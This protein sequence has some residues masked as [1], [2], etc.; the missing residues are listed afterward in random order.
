MILSVGMY[1]TTSAIANIGYNYGKEKGI[2]ITIE[3]M[4]ETLDELETIHPGICDEAIKT[5]HN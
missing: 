2:N 3:G 1:L 5:Y 4:K